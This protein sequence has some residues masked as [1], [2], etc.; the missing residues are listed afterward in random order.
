[1]DIRVLNE[2]KALEGE[3]RDLNERKDKIQDKIKELENSP[4]EDIVRGSS[5]VFPYTPMNMH[6]SGV[7]H[8]AVD[9][10]KRAARRLNDL[11]EHKE[12]EILE[13][14]ADVEEFLSGVHDSVLRQIIRHRVIDKMKW[15][16]VADKV[17][18]SEGSCKMMLKRFME[19]QNVT[20]VTL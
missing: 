14:H 18:G 3:L 6:I 11:I 13:K 1:M 4:C 5:D 19:E 8:V 17:N 15:S 16:E 9:R 10:K 20:H 7:D 2:Y 12:A